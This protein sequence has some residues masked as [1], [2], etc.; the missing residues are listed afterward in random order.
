MLIIKIYYYT[1]EFKDAPIVFSGKL[2]S[3]SRMKLYKVRF[4]YNAIKQDGM[5]VPAREFLFELKAA[6]ADPEIPK[7]IERYKALEVKMKL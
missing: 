3:I 6:K 4:V 1:N 2:D 7:L 5:S